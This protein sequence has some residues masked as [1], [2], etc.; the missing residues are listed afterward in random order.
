MQLYSPQKKLDIAVYSTDTPHH[1]YLLQRL[2]NDLPVGA[3][4]V[5]T[6]FETKPYPWKK[7][8]W[9]WLRNCF[10]NIIKGVFLN[11][12]LQPKSFGVRQEAFENLAFFSDGDNSIPDESNLQIV[13]SINSSEASDLIK[14]AQPDIAIVFGTGKIKPEIFSIPRLGTVNA[15]GGKLPEYRG[16]DT[17]LWAAYQGRIQDM[18][19]TLHEMDV[20]LDTGKVLMERQIPISKEMNLRSIRYFTTLICVDMYLNLF[21]KLLES[22]LEQPPA[23]DSESNYYGPMPWLLKMHTDRTL[24]R[25][26]KLSTDLGN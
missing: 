25:H 11:P 3:R 9:R 2:I 7:N 24:R 26:A 4:I 17:N 14:G 12:Y 16:L 10:P 19:V 21:S 13:S 6:I 1:R 8:R 5:L 20:E 22:G 18:F 15:H 23:R